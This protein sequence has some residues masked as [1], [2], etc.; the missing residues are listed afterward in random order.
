MRNYK[1]GFVGIVVT[2]II[3]LALIGGVYFIT[4]NKPQNTVAIEVPDNSATSS[5][6]YNG[7]KFSISGDDEKKALAGITKEDTAA[8]VRTSDAYIKYVNEGDMNDAYNIFS[9]IEQK[10][11][12]LMEFKSDEKAIQSATK[13]YIK[14]TSPSTIYAK[15]DEGTDYI[16]IELK[17]QAIF[18]GGSTKTLIVDFV[19]EN[20]VWKTLN[21]SFSTP[22][23]N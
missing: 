23:K 3:A 15:N 10:K 11:M 17:T 16:Y 7:V 1:Q 12:S 4:R 6:E 18:S 22:V 13:G 21:T 8:M 19:K 2:T 14:Q 5:Y 20:G 9:T